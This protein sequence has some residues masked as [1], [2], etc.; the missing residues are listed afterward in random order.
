[1][2]VAAVTAAVFES[3]SYILSLSVDPNGHYISW[4]SWHAWYEFSWV[5][6]REVQFWNRSYRTGPNNKLLPTYTT[7]VFLNTKKCNQPLHHRYLESHLH[8]NNIKIASTIEIYYLEIFKPYS[9][10]RPSSAS[11]YPCRSVTSVSHRSVLSVTYIVYGRGRI[12]LRSTATAL[13]QP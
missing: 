8:V 12:T 13:A 2:P 11:W 7:T 1:M 5:A 10:K 6:T 4:P 3:T 9:I